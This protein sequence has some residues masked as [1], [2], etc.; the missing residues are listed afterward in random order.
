MSILL[1]KNT[2]K[3]FEEKWSKKIKVFFYESWCSWTKIDIIDEFEVD[4]EIIEIT[5]QGPHS[6]SP[7]GRE[8][9]TVIPSPNGRGLGWGL[10]AGGELK[11]YVQKKDIEKLENCSITRVVKADHT[12]KEKVRYIYKSEEVKWRCG[13]GSSFSFEKKEP[14]LDIDKLKNLKFN[15]SAWK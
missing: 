14:K 2:L 13:C 9:A 5:I 3:Y 12:G 6:I 7:K 11:I 4:D 1:D 8:E 10:W 15:F